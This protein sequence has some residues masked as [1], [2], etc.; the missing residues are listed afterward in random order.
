MSAKLPP[1]DR[2]KQI[3]DEALRQAAVLGYTNIRREALAAA[4]GVSPSLVNLYFTTMAAL[5]RD[6][7]RAA[8]RGQCLP[9]IAQG[10]AAK[11]NH[12]RKAP[13][14]VQKAALAT[15]TA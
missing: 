12:A 13:L 5:K 14:D 9:V 2:K 1:A 11:D 15:L 7:M 3:L 8:V 6:V 4:I 10:L